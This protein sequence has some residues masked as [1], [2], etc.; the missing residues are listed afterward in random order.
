MNGEVIH[1]KPYP[2]LGE[3]KIGMNSREV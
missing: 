3:V 2:V 1:G